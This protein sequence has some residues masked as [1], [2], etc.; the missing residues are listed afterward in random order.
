MVAGTTAAWAGSANISG[1]NARRATN[2]IR[3]PFVLEFF[4]FIFPLIF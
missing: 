1:A 3:S 2:K 4:I